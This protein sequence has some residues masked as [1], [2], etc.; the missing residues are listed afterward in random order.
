M[1]LEIA[2]RPRIGENTSLQL[3]RNV[4]RLFAGPFGQGVM[5]FAE[6]IS[7]NAY[8][9]GNPKQYSLLYQDA[10]DLY[11]FL[12]ISSL[13]PETVKI[14]DPKVRHTVKG[15]TFTNMRFRF[16][17][18][19]EALEVSLSEEVRRRKIEANLI[20]RVDWRKV[21][22]FQFLGVAATSW[23]VMPI[24]TEMVVGKTLD[25][26]RFFPLPEKNIRRDHFMECFEG[27][28]ELFLTAAG[29]I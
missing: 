7:Q 27:I 11:D 19:E 29:A 20:R 18:R 23:S 21:S 12:L 16:Y 28:Q 22:E 25:S 14:T 5:S 1:G 6:L 3:S 10:L 2:D 17:D 13:A 9:A 8:K 4:R 15:G 26:R 24:E